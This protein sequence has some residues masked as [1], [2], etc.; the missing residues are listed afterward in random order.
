MNVEGHNLPRNRG[1]WQTAV[2]QKSLWD[3]KE[4]EHSGCL[5]SSQASTRLIGM[6]TAVLQNSSMSV[7]SCGHLRGNP[8]WKSKKNFQSLGFQRKLTL[9]FIVFRNKYQVLWKEA[10]LLLGSWGTGERLWPWCNLLA[11]GKE[12]AGGIEAFKT[13]TIET[14]HSFQSVPG[15]QG[16]PGMKGHL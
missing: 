12:A 13:F 15:S 9:I 2:H 14:D 7:H 10:C 4:S 5:I 16:L 1:R 6:K 8:F 3:D 11:R